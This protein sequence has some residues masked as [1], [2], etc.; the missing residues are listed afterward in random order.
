V[1]RAFFA[2]GGKDA[3]KGNDCLIGY[4]FV[5]PDQVTQDGKKNVVVCTDC[6]PSCDLDGVSTANGSCTIDAGVCI[7]QS[8]VEG[9]TPPAAL[10]KASAKGK[11]KGVK[12]DAGKIVIEV[13]Q[14][15][16]G[17][18][19]GAMVGVVIPVKVTKK[20]AK[21]GSASLNLSASV[22]KNKAEGIVGRS[23]KDKLTYVCQPRPE[24][25]ACPIATTT[26]STVTTTITST[27]IEST[28]TTVAS[29]TSTT[30]STSTSS[31]STTSTVVS[32]STTLVS[33][34]TTVAST[35]TTEVTSTST[36]STTATTI[37]LC[38]NNT[39]DPGEQC[40]GTDLG[41]ATC[42]SS[43][44]AAL[45]CT[46]ECTLDYSQCPGD[47]T[48]STTTPSST[49]S[50]TLEGTSTSTSTTTTITIAS[51]TSTSTTIIVTTTT[52]STSLP[53]GTV[54]AF[55]T[56]EPAGPC[57]AVKSGGAGGTTRKVL[58]CGGLN[59]G[60]GASTVAEGPT[61]AGAQTLINVS[62]TGATLSLSGRTSAQTGSNRNCSDTGCIFGPYLPIANAGTSTCVQNTF[63]SPASGTL[64]VT[65][66][67]VNG[68]FPLTSTV[69]LTA[70][71]SDPCPRCLGGTP[72]VA[73]SGT[74]QAGWT[75]GVGASPDEGDPCTPTDTAGDN[76]DCAPP[77]GAVLPSFP[78]NLT[79]ITTS[80]A[81]FSNAGGLFCPSQANS[82]AFGCAGSGS[83][84]AICPGGNNPP[85]IDYI[86]EVGS[87]A[88]LLSAGTHDV[89]LASTFCIPSVGGSLGFLINGAANLPGPGA[90][91]LPGTLEL[92]D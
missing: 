23:D 37:D 79:P 50:T 10:D 41:G 13:P 28:S 57:G 32:T 53:T 31:T 91:S 84:N 55:T 46:P 45:L 65:T 56:G 26:S 9:C 71:A 92:L 90:T 82:G 44:S 7:N 58:N 11:V 68:S 62:G 63:A 85:L 33:T 15:L 47:T 35:S 49:T 70:N 48:T 76:Y 66:G 14:L 1:S 43:P 22:K 24:G 34:S 60:G 5:D 20:G 61:P 51:T 81:S 21:D 27:T 83:A 36:T 64:D 75:S 88:G 59:V 40:D 12:G 80:T 69:Y 18:A 38:G 73:N 39:I 89:T 6:D 72:G 29:S 16:E 17:S 74:C 67:A 77:A 3:A 42:V 78:V 19:C 52:T 25:D 54:L 87:P 86:E 8:G 4:N 2:G 30:T